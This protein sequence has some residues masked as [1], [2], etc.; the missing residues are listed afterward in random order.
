MISIGSD[1]MSHAMSHVGLMTCDTTK[2][3]ANTLP[4]WRTDPNGRHHVGVQRTPGPL[5]CRAPGVPRPG[6]EPSLGLRVGGPFSGGPRS[7]D[8]ARV[9]VEEQIQTQATL[10][11]TEP[12]LP[13][14][15]GGTGSTPSAPELCQTPQVTESPG[16]RQDLLDGPS[17]HGKATSRPLSPGR[18]SGERDED[19]SRPPVH[20]PASVRAGAWPG[21]TK[22][23]KMM[24]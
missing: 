9:R 13:G 23:R 17:P 11:T 5:R 15:R 3:K 22:C 19:A 4:A 21:E 2:N 24:W 18:A 12:S 14:N 1:N 8:G 10:P 20:W 16:N 6:T 7:A